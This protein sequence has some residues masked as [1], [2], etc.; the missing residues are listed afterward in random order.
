MNTISR[1]TV[2]ELLVATELSKKELT[3]CLPLNH[4]SEYD[5]IVDNKKELK[6]IQV[7]RAYQVNNHGTKVLC[8][9][10]RRI[11]V[12]HSGKKG[13][14]A[15]RYSNKGY[16]YLIACDVDNNN[17]WIIPKKIA[18][19]YKAQIYLTSK[20]EVYKNQWAKLVVDVSS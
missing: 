9:E 17:F 20:M 4:N 3:V 2:A 6:K 1:G 8:V 5:L 14:V 10:T 13:S 11:L 19:N 16:D 15:R 12:K 18:D 7:K